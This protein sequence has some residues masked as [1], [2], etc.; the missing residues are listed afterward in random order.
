MVKKLTSFMAITV[1]LFCASMASAANMSQTDAGGAVT[2]DASNV[3]GANDVIFQPSSQVNISGAS[4]ETSFAAISGHQAVAGKEAGQNYGMAADSSNVFW[5]A[6]ASTFP[7][8]TDT[9]SG[10]FSTNSWNRN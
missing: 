6:A 8:L 3:T 7:T 10:Y 1:L 9:N 5:L 4:E 2:V